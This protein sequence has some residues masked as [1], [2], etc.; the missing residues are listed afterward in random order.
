MDEL[1]TTATPT[2]NVYQLTFIGIGFQIVDIAL[3]LILA[4][5]TSFMTGFWNV[6]FGG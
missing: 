3:N 4:I 2:D 6:L 5:A 1:T